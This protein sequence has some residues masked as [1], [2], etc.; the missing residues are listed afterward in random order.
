L[1]F[2]DFLNQWAV[3]QIEEN[4][5]AIDN[6]RYDPQVAIATETDLDSSVEDIK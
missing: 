6:M 2:Y 4:E 3:I 5:E 1:D